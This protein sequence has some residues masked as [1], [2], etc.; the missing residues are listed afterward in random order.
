VAERFLAL[1]LATP[2]GEKMRVLMQVL[3]C[4]PVGL[5]YEIGGEFISKIAE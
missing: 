5:F 2:S 4:R 1:E 3:R